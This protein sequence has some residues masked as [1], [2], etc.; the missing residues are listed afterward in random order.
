MT[1]VHDDKVEEVRRK[2]LAE[3]LL[4]IIAHQLLVQG[5]I[6]LVGGDGAFIVLGHI[7]LV[8][9]LFQRGKILLNGLIHQNVPVG[10]IEDLAL[11]AALQHP[12]HD[13]EGGIGLAGAGGHHQKNPLLPPGNGIHRAVDGDTLVIA[14]RVG[15]LAGVVRLLPY[16][17]LPRCDTGFL[18][19]LGGQL[20]FCGELVQTKLALLPGQEIVFYKSIP[21]GAVRK[22]NIQHLCIGHRL[23]QSMGNAVRIVLCLYNGNGIVCAEI[24]DIIRA[25][26]LFAEHKVA[27]QVDF[28][29]CDAGFHSDFI[30]IPLG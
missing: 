11:H 9:D 13:L 27:L 3:M 6:H 28:T 23:L 7:D 22:G 2:Q 24:Q 14:G 25:F 29:V 21:V 16:C 5:K 15:V 18:L 19:I 30:P 8:G 20:L 1:L 26:G 4:V 17:L 10:Q 12:V